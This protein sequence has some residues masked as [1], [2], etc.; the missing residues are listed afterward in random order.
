[1]QQL[2]LCICVRLLPRRMWAGGRTKWRHHAKHSPGPR[3]SPENSGQPVHARQARPRAVSAA[4]ST[5]E[6]A[7]RS[8][9]MPFT[10]QETKGLARK[11]T[12]RGADRPHPVCESCAASAGVHRFSVSGLRSSF[13]PMESGNASPHV[14]LRRGKQCLGCTR[15]STAD[16]TEAGLDDKGEEGC[17]ARAD[18]GH[19]TAATPVREEASPDPQKGLRGNR[20]RLV[21]ELAPSHLGCWL[22]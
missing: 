10:S 15:Q 14:T 7:T 3:S 2:L 5:A 22:L 19:C 20:G 11:A 9:H 21:G 1:M 16:V 8:V 13:V 4:G 18:R 12:T 6:G 17:E